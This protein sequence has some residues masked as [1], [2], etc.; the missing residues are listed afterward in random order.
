MVAFSNS[1]P[2]YGMQPGQPRV[3]KQHFAQ[4]MSQTMVD[5]RAMNPAMAG[6]MVSHMSGQPR[7]NQPRPMVMT[8]M[9]QG[10]PSMTP[11]NQGPGQPMAGSGGLVRA[12]RATPA[13]LPADSQSGPYVQLRQPARQ[14]R[15]L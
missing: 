3:A 5:P 15:L 14:R 9:G 6:Q 11:F 13:G 4:G 12:G 8:S 2:A 1:S 10:V 7:T